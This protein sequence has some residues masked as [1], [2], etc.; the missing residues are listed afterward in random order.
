MSVLLTVAL[1]FTACFPTELQS[2]IDRDAV[3]GLI[4]FSVK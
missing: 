1:A 3:K 4:P 2:P